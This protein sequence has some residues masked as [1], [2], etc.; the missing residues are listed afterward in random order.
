MDRHSSQP[1]S[2]GSCSP[3]QAQ[4]AAFLDVVFGYCEGLIPVRAYTDKGQGAN[5][6]PQTLWVPA[7]SAA[8]EKIAEFSRSRAD[9]GMGVF[10]VPGTVAK[11]GQ[12]KAA[13]ILQMQTV[14]VDLDQGD[15]G[16]KRD[17]LAR[18]LGEPTL[19][20]ASGGVTAE[21]Q[22]KLHL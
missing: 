5:R 10:V 11:A 18:H 2:G 15:I 17:H 6:A 7:G 19:E 22:R 12:A 4:I 21:G 20:V 8:A 13:E 1:L 14:L 16:A 9:A 3:D